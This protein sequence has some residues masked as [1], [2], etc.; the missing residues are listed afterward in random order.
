M[1]LKMKDLKTWLKSGSE[2]YAHH[3]L[4]IGLLSDAESLAFVEDKHVALSG[5]MHDLSTISLDGTLL[6]IEEVSGEGD[7]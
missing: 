1:S 7:D 2:V 5:N 6:T 4:G 3:M